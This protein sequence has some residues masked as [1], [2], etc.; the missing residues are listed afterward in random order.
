MKRAVAL[1]LVLLL[2]ATGVLLGAARGQARVAG[3]VVLCTGAAVTLQAIDVNG[4]PVQRAA[5][6]PDMALS[7]LSALDVPPVILP[8]PEGTRA[9]IASVRSDL[10]SGAALFRMQPR[11]PPASPTV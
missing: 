2:S 1:M 9:K 6:C 8:A 10:P 7:L 11:G 5:I 4:Q 3:H